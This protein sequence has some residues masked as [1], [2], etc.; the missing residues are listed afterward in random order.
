MKPIFCLSN[1]LE[2]ASKVT[3]SPTP[4]ALAI[5]STRCIHDSTSLSSDPSNAGICEANTVIACAVGTAASVGMLLMLPVPPSEVKGVTEAVT[6]GS[7]LVVETSALRD[8]DH[9]RPD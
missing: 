9:L 6:Q 3:S 7:V 4:W 8:L 5:R 2:A 1:L